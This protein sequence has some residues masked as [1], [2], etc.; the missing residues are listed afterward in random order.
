MSK[1]TFIIAQLT[2]RYRY[3][4]IDKVGNNSFS[5]KGTSLIDR[6]RYSFIGTFSDKVVVIESSRPIELKNRISTYTR[7]L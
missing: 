3:V 6:K 1:E 5:G 2:K 4:V 7:I